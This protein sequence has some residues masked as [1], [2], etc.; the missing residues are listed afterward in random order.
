[1]EEEI[2]KA[3]KSYLL[4]HLGKEVQEMPTDVLRSNGKVEQ[5]WDGAF[6]VGGVLYL[7]EAKHSMNVDHLEKF[8]QRI[9]KFKD[10]QPYVQPE[11]KEGIEQV[12]GVACGV[13]MAPLVL[14]KAKDLGLMCVY[15]S[16]NRYCVDVI[17]ENFTI[18]NFN[19]QV[20]NV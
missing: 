2:S 15:P 13:Y 9:Q 16:G 3:M 4:K 5:E 20:A 19:V 1:M 10:L 12:I 11:F 17:P 8:P 6:K 7:C 18:E 14:K